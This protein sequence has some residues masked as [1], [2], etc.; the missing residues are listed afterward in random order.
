MNRVCKYTLLYIGFYYNLNIK[1]LG[2][3]A[4]IVNDVNLRGVMGVENE[5]WRGYEQN[6]GEKT[7]LITIL[8]RKSG[9]IA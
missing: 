3:G 6:K 8:D 9:K 2:V 4:G 1:V 5:H 7:C